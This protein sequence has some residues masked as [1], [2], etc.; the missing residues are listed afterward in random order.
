MFVL[1]LEGPDFCGKSTIATAL[2]LRMRKA[3]LNVERTELPSRLITGIFTDLLRNSKD[4]IAPEVFALVYAADHLHHYN[5][6]IKQNSADFLILER[7]ALSFFV[8]EGL[9]L[10]V[11]MNWLKELN[12]YNGTKPDLTVVLK[13]PEEELLRRAKIRK[14]SEDSF[15][16]EEF[17]RK[18]AKAFY[19]L[20]SWLKREF[21]VVYVEQRDIEGTV[22]E[23]MEKIKSRDI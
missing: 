8:Y 11:D 20:P 6:V 23:I 18:V 15:E 4:K 13:V 22:D 14:G 16:K 1:A 2:L 19:N 5:R 17:I 12:K 3:G 7:S 21:N 9:V 10:G